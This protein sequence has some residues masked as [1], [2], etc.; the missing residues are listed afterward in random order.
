MENLEKLGKFLT[1]EE[2]QCIMGGGDPCNTSYDCADSCVNNPDAI[3]GT[4][5]KDGVCTL[6]PFICP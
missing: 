4:Y 2:M 6:W 1:K 3:H 5:C